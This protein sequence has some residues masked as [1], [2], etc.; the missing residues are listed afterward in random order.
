MD[1]N[2]I[3]KRACISRHHEKNFYCT[4]PIGEEGGF[5][6]KT[7]LEACVNVEQSQFYFLGMGKPILMPGKSSMIKTIFL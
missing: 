5:M 4:N 6:D 3:L 1:I 2:I 7:D